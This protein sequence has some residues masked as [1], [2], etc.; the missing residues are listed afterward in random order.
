MD[1]KESKLEIAKLYNEFRNAHGVTNDQTAAAL[2]LATVLHA[3]DVNL[4][5]RVEMAWPEKIGGPVGQ[6]GGKF[7]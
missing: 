4:N 6:Y 7:G 2:T 1:L 3:K 5:T